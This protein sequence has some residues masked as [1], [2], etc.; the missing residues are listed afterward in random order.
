MN[1]EMHVFLDKPY[2]LSSL[3]YIDN[4]GLVPKNTMRF[5]NGL[6]LTND[7]LHNRG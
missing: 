1:V 5:I 4:K 3:G 2:N 6:H 7:G